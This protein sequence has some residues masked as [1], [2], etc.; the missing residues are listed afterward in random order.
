MNTLERTAWRASRD[1]YDFPGKAMLAV[2]LFAFVLA[3]VVLAAH[4]HD[5]SQSSGGGVQTGTGPVAQPNPRIG[6]PSSYPPKHQV[7]DCERE[8][9][10]RDIDL[11][12]CR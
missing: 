3:I 2:A 5:L 1:A 8:R 10:W 7:T 4:R 11:P 9:A 6:H 12:E